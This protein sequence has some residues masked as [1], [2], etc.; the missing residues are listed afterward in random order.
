MHKKLLFAFMSCLMLYGCA[1]TASKTPDSS[2]SKGC[3]VFEECETTVDTPTEET[4]SFKED[5][6]SL[7]GTENKKGKIHRT[8]TIPETVTFTYTTLSDVIAKLDNKENFFLYIGDAKCPW[9][10]AVI[11][12]AIA[13]AE[14]YGIKEILYVPIWDEDG[15]ELF[16]DKYTVNEGIPFHESDGSN[17]YMELLG[18]FRD[19]LK[20][21]EI[22]EV[23]VGEKRIYAPSFFRIENGEAVFMT[24]G[25]PESLEDPRTEI[26]EEQYSEMKAYFDNLFKE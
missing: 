22:D 24:E 7:N 17:E 1:E 4:V 26:A 16:R 6:E 11:E 9:C 2:G 12:T 14:E 20:D 10:R 25:I 18:R 23:S 19:V 13:K 5:Y 21:Y 3:D 15:N 8:I